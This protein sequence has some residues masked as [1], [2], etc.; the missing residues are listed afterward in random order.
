MIGSDFSG[1]ALSWLKPTSCDVLVSKRSRGFVQFYVEFEY[2]IYSHIFEHTCDY[3]RCRR[4]HKAHLKSFLITHIFIFLICYSPVSYNYCESSNRA[5]WKKIIHSRKKVPFFISFIFL[6]NRAL[7]LSSFQT[8]RAF[9]Q[10]FFQ[11][12]FDAICHCHWFFC[13]WCFRHHYGQCLVCSLIWK[14]QIS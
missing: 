8:H 12:L 2:Q 11:I 7:F 10:M 1:P 13:F 4:I 14:T 6:F 9:G 3:C 5:K